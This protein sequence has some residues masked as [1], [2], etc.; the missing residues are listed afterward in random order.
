MRHKKWEFRLTEED[1]QNIR[2]G[3]QNAIRRKLLTEAEREDV[4]QELVLRLQ[5]ATWQFKREKSRWETFRNIL[6]RTKLLDLIRVRTQPSAYEQ[7]K[8]N[9]SI[10]DPIPTPGGE[11]GELTRKDAISQDGVFADGT[12]RAE[13]VERLELII[14]VREAVALMPRHLKR[15]SMLMM[16][17]DGCSMQ[18]LA[19]K[20][21]V[22]RRTLFVWRGELREYLSG[23]GF[24]P[25]I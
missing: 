2:C 25:L 13:E 22:N 18:E 20:L 17:S 19:R 10:D 16:Y 5:E 3:V 12:E 23:Y 7:R 1:L 9:F 8:A 6:I 15:L 11:P 24:G 21:K 4:E 14:D